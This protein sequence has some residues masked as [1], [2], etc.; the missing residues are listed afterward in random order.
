M[1]YIV[2][3]EHTLR[4]SAVDVLARK[5]SRAARVREAAHAMLDIPAWPVRRRI[6]RDWKSFSHSNRCTKYREKTLILYK[7]VAEIFIDI[8][9]CTK[10][11]KF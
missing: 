6:T 11:R 1:N 3:L 2:P 4:K 5:E 10:T 9:E 8:C 7:K